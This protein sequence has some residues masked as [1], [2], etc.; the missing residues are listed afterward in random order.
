VLQ[1]VPETD[2]GPGANDTPGWGL[3][4]MPGRLSREAGIWRHLWPL[5][6]HVPDAGRAAARVVP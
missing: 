3:G 1:G 4:A 6:A 2:D 5:L